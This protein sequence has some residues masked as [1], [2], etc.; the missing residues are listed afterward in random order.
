MLNNYLGNY[1]T[2]RSW[3]NRVPN[4]KYAPH[5]RKVT[6]RRSTQSQ[7]TLPTTPGARESGG[8]RITDVLW[9]SNEISRKSTNY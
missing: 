5:V 8:R 4:K 6:R 3:A 9:R 2:D 7:A 1:I